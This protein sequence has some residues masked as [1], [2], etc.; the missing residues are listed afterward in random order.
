MAVALCLSVTLVYR[1]SFLTSESGNFFEGSAAEDAANRIQEKIGNGPISL[2]MIEIYPDRLEMD[3]LSPTEPHVVN[4]YTFAEGKITGPV[5]VQPAT[6][7][8]DT[9]THTEI[10]HFKLS[11]VSL[12]NVPQLCQ[13]SL[14]RAGLN[15]PKCEQVQIG[16]VYASQAYP[17][18]SFLGDYG[19]ALITGWRISVRSG[20]SSK[21]YFANERGEMQELEIPQ[22]TIEPAKISERRVSGQ[23]PVKLKSTGRFSVN[24]NRHTFATTI[25]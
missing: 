23:K 4:R 19:K 11:D 22:A 20:Q 10:H 13:R 2:N 15:D 12:W 24:G 1:P 7:A 25:I 9:S 18:V 3:I 17:Y 5:K 6:L 16:Q 14:R 8:N 21:E